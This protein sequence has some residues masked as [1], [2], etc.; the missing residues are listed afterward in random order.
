MWVEFEIDPDEHPNDGDA[1]TV[2]VNLDG[3][4]RI[5]ESR[6]EIYQNKF[7]LYLFMS[8]DTVRLGYATLAERQVVV[9]KLKNLLGWKPIARL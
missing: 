1:P 6:S 7:K 2:Y 3:V 4:L 5:E 9:D 8:G